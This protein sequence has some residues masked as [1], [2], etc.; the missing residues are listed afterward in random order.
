MKNRLNEVIIAAKKKPNRPKADEP[1]EDLR[2]KASTKC[3]VREAQ[4]LAGAE[5]TTA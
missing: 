5:P 1:R 2:S 3:G 4:E